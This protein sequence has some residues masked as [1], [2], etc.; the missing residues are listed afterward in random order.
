[1][2]IEK[3]LKRNILRNVSLCQILEPLADKENC[4]TRKIDSS[5]GTKLE[6]FLISSINSSWSFYDLAEKILSDKKQ[7]NCIYNFAYESQ[8]MS[9]LNR[10]GGKINFGQISLLIPLVTAQVLEYIDT[11]VTN[12]VFNICKRT[13]QVIQ[14]TTS[15]DVKYLEKFI[16]SARQQSYEHHLNLGER[17]LIKKETK[18]EYDNVWDTAQAYKNNDIVLEIINE[19]ENSL[20][21]FNI[22]EKNI[23]KGILHGSEIAY[24][25]LYP[26]KI[27]RHDGVADLIVSAFYLILTAHKNK[28]LLP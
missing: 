14:N 21:I 16:S 15:Q 19:Y 2:N 11:G 20:K 25:N 24:K 13:K 22:L 26:E 27:K 10:S 17:N 28:N 4:T 7:P 23:D 12:D 9:P 18:L 5:I 8:L 1:M 3:K 6:Y